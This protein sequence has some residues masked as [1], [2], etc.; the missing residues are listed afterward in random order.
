MMRQL[1][2][3]AVQHHQRLWLLLTLML[4]MLVV[5]GFQL[6]GQLDTRGTLDLA[7][8]MLPS[9]MLG[10]ALGQTTQTPIQRLAM[11]GLM[12]LLYLV[13]LSSGLFLLTQSTFQ[14]PL[15]VNSVLLLGLVYGGL[16]SVQVM[17]E[18]WLLLMLLGTL[19]L[20]GQLY[21][22]RWPILIPWLV[23]IGWLGYQGLLSLT[24]VP[25]SYPGV[26]AAET[27]A[28]LPVI[29]PV[30][31]GVSIAEYLYLTAHKNR[32]IPK[33]TTVHLSD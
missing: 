23:P 1:R 21:H 5:T 2:E 19:Q 24:A 10:G 27:L 17:F 18:W 13:V 22:H 9:L 4:L 3:F 28:L 20:I 33:D 7:T 14:G 12:N 31:T 8:I 15:Q 11:L 16:V 30:I 25:W 32:R 6:K 29:V 26:F